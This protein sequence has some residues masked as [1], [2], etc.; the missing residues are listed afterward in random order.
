MS[1]ARRSQS[2]AMLAFVAVVAS[3][4]AAF[5]ACTSYSRAN[6]EECLKDV[7]C[8]SGF[9]LAQKCENPQPILVGPSYGPAAATDAGS[10][11]DTSMSAPDTAPPPAPDSSTA[12]TG[13]DAPATGD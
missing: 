1:D 10:A 9:C 12:D 3:L 2:R 13:S 5:G 4:G 8:L 11:A 7:D 6:G